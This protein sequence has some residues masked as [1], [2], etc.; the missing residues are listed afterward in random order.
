MTAEHHPQG[1]QEILEGTL[2]EGVSGFVP[3]RGRYDMGLLV[4]CLSA[5]GA[6]LRHNSRSDLTELRWPP[7]SLPDWAP[8]T[9]RTEAL[10][11]DTFASHLQ[12]K[13]SKGLKPIIWQ[14]DGRRGAATAAARTTAWN[15]HLALNEHDPVEDY[16]DSLPAWDG[17]PRLD[18]VFE[19]AGFRL[20]HP[21]DLLVRW[22]GAAIFLAAVWRTFEPGYGFHEM[23]V[24]QGPQRAG[25][26]QFLAHLVP[27]EHRD[28][29][30]TDNLQLASRSGTSKE[31]VE[32]TLG[33]WIVEC[34][35]LAGLW[36]S[37]IEP[38]KAYLS[39]SADNAVRLAWRRNAELRP[40]RFVVVGTT[41]EAR[42]LPDDPTGNRRFVV[43]EVKG[44]N[45]AQI[46]GWVNEHRDQLWA[47]AVHRVNEGEHARLP[48]GLGKAQASAN[49]ELRNRDEKAQ[50]A[51]DFFLT[52]YRT[53]YLIVSEL[54]S[55]VKVSPTYRPPVVD[56]REEHAFM[57]ISGVEREVEPGLGYEVTAKAVATVLRAEGWT[58]GQGRSKAYG[59][60]M[61]RYWNKPVPDEPEDGT[62][63]EPVQASDQAVPDV[64]LTSAGVPMYDDMQV[65]KGSAGTTGTKSPETASDQHV[66]DV[67]DATNPTGTNQEQHERKFVCEDEGCRSEEA[68]FTT[69]AALQEHWRQEH[70]TRSA[71]RPGEGDLR[72]Y[73]PEYVYQTMPLDLIV[74]VDS[75]YVRYK[76]A[77]DILTLGL[78]DL[79]DW[80]EPAAPMEEHPQPPPADRTLVIRLTDG[81]WVRIPPDRVSGR[82]DDGRVIVLDDLGG[83][84]TAE[85]GGP[86]AELEWDPPVIP[87]D[88]LY[89]E[90]G[91]PR[92]GT[93]EVPEST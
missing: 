44:G 67:P 50:G 20:E 85:V 30:F 88:V 72:I 93:A 84:W 76:H 74:S 25:K 80:V 36:R 10:L 38:M 65:N 22:A 56:G 7:A 37:D 2:P 39:R 48:D 89:S 27:P 62:G 86:V 52:S 90:E 87:E 75:R 11:W 5:V 1:D 26:S 57:L 9:D 49:E 29:W 13:T 81:G 54:I 61:I 41:N 63:T 16:L 12:Y 14:G 69:P 43:V 55:A 82:H 78:S 60:R 42:P 33:K 21:D 19:L 8:I 79:T 77:G 6:E 23:P 40:R 46:I 34:A 91:N 17:E 45:A 68:R 28:A 24:L 35:E 15:A 83:E 73:N 47:E 51:V 58:P 66:P 64:P 53:E 31:Q 70:P 32:A 18:R 71:V 92:Q 4:D 3:W 59:G